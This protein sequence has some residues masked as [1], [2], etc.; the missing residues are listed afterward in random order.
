M[1]TKGGLSE[2]YEFM[3]A[4]VVG[5][6]SGL[7]A[8]GSPASGL[9][10]SGLPATYN[11]RNS[12]NPREVV[13]FKVKRVVKDDIMEWVAIKRCIGNGKLDQM[14]LQKIGK[15]LGL[16]GNAGD[17]DE[18]TPNE[19]NVFIREFSRL[20]NEEI[21]LALQ[22]KFNISRPYHLAI[23]NL[24]FT[25][26]DLLEHL[27][28]RAIEKY[29]TVLKIH[30]KKIIDFGKLEADAAEAEPTS[31]SPL[32]K[33]ILANEIFTDADMP[34]CLASAIRRFNRYRA[35]YQYIGFCP[36]VPKERLAKLLEFRAE[37]LLDIIVAVDDTAT[38]CVDFRKMIHELEAIVIE[39]GNM[40]TIEIGDIDRVTPSGT[41]VER[42]DIYMNIYGKMLP[43]LEQAEQNSIDLSRRIDKLIAAI[44]PLFS[45]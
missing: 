5:G 13:I 20:T 38:I 41:L 43:Y 45:V 37:R 3:G 16:I 10:A 18:V 15:L 2:V 24:F 9:P 23:E 6:A 11:V 39:M 44:Y 7:P 28:A 36:R 27:A 35:K 34:D 42:I 21:F 29:N 22:N 1:R 12:N 4:T 14:S 25:W 33:Y 31:S 8:S 40:P 32:L 26:K 30:G 19:I 17:A